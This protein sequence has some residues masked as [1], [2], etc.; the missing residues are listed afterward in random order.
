MAVRVRWPHSRQESDDALAALGI[1]AYRPRVVAVA[2]F[3]LGTA[4]FSA[5]DIRKLLNYEPLHRDTELLLSW[6][7]AASFTAGIVEITTLV[8]IRIPVLYSKSKG[9]GFGNCYSCRSCRPTP[10]H[11][12]LLEGAAP[13]LSLF[14]P[15][16]SCVSASSALSPFPLPSL[17]VLFW[18]LPGTARARNS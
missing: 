6:C 18:L 14:L 15:I 8:L 10:P 17:S 7:I 1:T 2:D 5:Q 16:S 13:Y 4:E 3:G 11:G 12:S 9:E